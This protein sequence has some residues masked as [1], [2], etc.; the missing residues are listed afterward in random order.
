MKTVLFGILDLEDFNSKEINVINLCILVAKMCI[1]K[2]KYGKLYSIT[3][4]FDNEMKLRLKYLP[5]IDR[6]S[7][8]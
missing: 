4:M 7:F 2:Y 1:S 8:Y 3:L 5:Y 6:D